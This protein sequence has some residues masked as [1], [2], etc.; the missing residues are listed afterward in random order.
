MKSDFRVLLL[1]V[2]SVPVSFQSQGDDEEVTSSDIMHALKMSLWM[3][4]LNSSLPRTRR[5]LSRKNN[6]ST[7]DFLSS[8]RESS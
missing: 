2:S 6:F 8:R 7:L 1:P 4:S 3:K 5:G